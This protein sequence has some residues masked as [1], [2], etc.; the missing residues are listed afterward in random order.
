MQ[1]AAAF[2]EPPAE[3]REGA[4][5]DWVAAPRPPAADELVAAG[6]PEWLAPL[7]ARRGVG[8]GEAA[9]RFLNPSLDQLHDPLRLYGVG[10]AVARLVAARDA[11]ER[12]AVVGDYDVDG[13]TATALLTAV[14]AACRIDAHPILPH[15]L[16]EGYGFQ[17]L[18]AERAAE[19][20][21]RLIVTV[22]CG[23]TS[24]AAVETAAAAG[25]DVVITDH[26]LPSGEL[27]AG[28]LL[29]NPRQELCDYPFAGL[30]G[31]GLALKLAQAV[32]AACGRQ[33]DPRAL[34]R[35]A[36]LGTIA[37]M[38]PLVDENRAIAALG[39]EALAD[40]PSLGLRALFRRAGVEPP[41]SA[42]DVGFRIGPR[43]NAAGRLDDAHGALELLTSRDRGRCEELAEQLDRLNRER[44]DEERRVVAEARDLLTARRPLPPIAV[45]WSPG[46]HR[47]VLG[48]AAGRLARE[49]HRPTVLL[50]VAED[51]ATGSGRSIPGIALHDFIAAWR[52]DLA[53][54]GGHDQ[55]VGLTVEPGRR[56]AAP[57]AAARRLGGDRRRLARGAAG[58]PPRVRAGAR[59]AP[60]DGALPRATWRASS[61]TARAIRSRW[62]G[63]DRSPSPARRASSASRPSTCRPRRP[64][65][66][67]AGWASSA[68]AGAT[69]PSAWPAA[70]RCSATWRWTATAAGRRSGC[71]TS[72]RWRTPADRSGGTAVDR[73]AVESR[74]ETPT[75]PAAPPAVP[76]P[77]VPCPPCP[78]SCSC[79]SWRCCR[80]PAG[81]WPPS[82]AEAAAVP[83]RLVVRVV[84]HDA[85]VLGD[86]VGGAQGGG[87][88]RRHG[89]GAGLRRPA[90]QHRR[91]RPHHAPAAGARRRHL[92]HRGRG[93]LPRHPRAAPADPR[94]D[95]RLRSVAPRPRHA[96]GVEA[97][98]AR[99]P[100]VT[101]RATAWCSSST[102]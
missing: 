101:S 64:E 22:D 51:S 87:P 99:C 89:R 28:T 96:A 16:R 43:L 63:S 81:R 58:A 98:V 90:R 66:T 17:P 7:L 92:R 21:C 42:A 82:V 57:R 84:A 55:A 9:R 61:R 62:R 75:D 10:A 50:A 30:A 23:V 69:G 95:H 46:W 39:L 65:T 80:H 47:G 67:V 36:C 29:V 18:H 93:G 70:S 86:H 3:L 100:A 72:A 49:L 71:S 25:L 2:E 8:D 32:A 20:G 35:V 59:A 79:R 91:H 78:P 34:L 41:L 68:G 19:L 60:R 44:Q 76:R 97:A 33:V 52:G 1:G 88:G 4:P 48:I 40:T 53:R 15:R 94:R 74:H 12:V 73:Q 83:T 26:H 85:K 27:P 38:V 45:A 13:I 31:V 54:F 56:A 77:A 6:L 5:P 11:G 24:A 37:D 102:A 14:L